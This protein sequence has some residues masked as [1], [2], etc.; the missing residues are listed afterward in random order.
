M[1]VTNAVT[2]TALHFS[3]KKSPWNRVSCGKPSQL[4]SGFRGFALDWALG[5]RLAL[6]VTTTVEFYA[7]T[8]KRP[9]R[10]TLPLSLDCKKAMHPKAPREPPTPRN[11]CELTNDGVLAK[12]IAR[13][14]DMAV[15][16]R[17]YTRGALVCVQTVQKLTRVC[18]RVPRGGAASHHR[19]RVIR[20]RVVSDLG[21]GGA[22]RG[23]GSALG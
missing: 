2:T 21:G 19:R 12:L 4:Q 23:V 5:T 6:V 14:R 16:C 7:R 20:V 11:F 15:H 8:R 22:R 18:D 17:R 13:G 3:K 10:G 9:L 1:P